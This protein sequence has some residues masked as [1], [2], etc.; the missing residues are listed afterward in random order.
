MG[1]ANY[2]GSDLLRDI[3]DLDAVARMRDDIYLAPMGIALAQQGVDRTAN[4][5]REHRLALQAAKDRLEEIESAVTLAAIMDGKIDGKNA[6]TRALQT[7]AI[8]SDHEAVIAA[9]EALS[10]AEHEMVALEARADDAATGLGYATNR[11]KAVL[12]RASYEAVILRAYDPFI[13]REEQENV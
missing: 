3:L 11:F 1:D 6:E 10:E 7:A 13:L 8:L 9:R 5:I 4:A 12:A 2:H